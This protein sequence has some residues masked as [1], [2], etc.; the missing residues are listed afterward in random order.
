MIS[1]IQQLAYDVIANEQGKRLFK[2]WQWHHCLLPEGKSKLSPYSHYICSG[3][4][5]LDNKVKTQDSENNNLLSLMGLTG[6]NRTLLTWG[7]LVR[8]SQRSARACGNLKS[9]LKGHLWWLKHLPDLRIWLGLPTARQPTSKRQ[10]RQFLGH[11]YNRHRTTSAI[12]H[13]PK[14]QAES[15]V[16][17]TI[18]QNTVSLNLGDS[19]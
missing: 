5:S 12:Y 15:L 4:L 10:K 17:Y 9:G 11:G 13:L 18:C 3:Y 16:P 7:S 19:P 2:K 8:C 1:D 14:Q 6:L